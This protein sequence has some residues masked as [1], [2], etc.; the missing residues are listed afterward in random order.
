[1]RTKPV[2]IIEM[3]QIVDKI[4]AA[5]NNPWEQ[6]K[7]SGFV[8]HTSSHLYIKINRLKNN[9]EITTTYSSIKRDHN[10]FKLKNGLPNE[11]IIEQVNKIGES[12]SNPAHHYQFSHFGKRDSRNIHVFIKNMKTNEIK[13]QRYG[14]LTKGQNP[15][16]QK[17]NYT[18]SFI[19]DQINEAGKSHVIPYHR[20]EFV[21]DTKTR[22]TYTVKNLITKELK[23]IKF[24]TIKSG[25]SPFANH[26]YIL[27]SEIK[28]Q[29]KKHYPQFKD[30]KISGNNYPYKKDTIYIL[31]NHF[32]ISYRGPKF[33]KRITVS[34][35]KARNFLNG[36]SISEKPS[37]VESNYI[38]YVNTFG[39]S[40]SS[41][42][43]K[44]E[45]QSFGKKLPKTI[46]VYVKNTTTNEVLKTSLDSLKKKSNPFKLRSHLSDMYI[47]EMVNAQGKISK[48]LSIEKILKSL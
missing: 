1:M 33:N 13:E 3:Q 36:Q 30:L 28:E 8:K 47:K 46:E 42:Y 29:F 35:F 45:F 24:Y 14:R 23:N 17:T 27:G 39:S 5:Q 21:R 20:Y 4:G 2:N 6:F 12:F 22:S 32:N 34:G 19:K 38:E 10:P 41:R 43:E 31:N 15:F 18:D 26:Y 11:F 40:F 7:F 48:E 9:D 44:F 16:V 25:I 37:D